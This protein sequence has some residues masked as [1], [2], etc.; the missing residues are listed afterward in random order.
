MSEKVKQADFKVNISSFEINKLITTS[1]L[2]SKIELMLSSR[3]VLR[4]IVDY[5]NSKLGYA[6]PTQR[7]IARCTGLSE[8]SVGQA[9]KELELKQL[10]KKEKVNKRLHYKFGISF[11]GYL[12]V[13]P[14]VTLGDTQ[15]SFGNIPQGAL[16]NNILKEK[17]NTFLNQ[18]LSEEAERP[19]TEE[20]VA[21][22]FIERLGN[23]K[24]FRGKVKALKEKFGL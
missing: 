18:T 1:N 12:E 8:V 5:L 21:K 4:C 23:S 24:E 22:V 17:E 19:M 16:D 9:V 14:K 11:L 20:E 10:I 6:Y 7:T 15:S 3:L 13:I 2:F